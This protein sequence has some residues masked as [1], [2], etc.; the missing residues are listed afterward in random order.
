MNWNAIRTDH[1]GVADHVFGPMRPAV[2]TAAETMVC[3]LRAGGK[4]LCC[5]NGGSAADAQHFAAEILNRFET[6]HEPWPALALTTDSSVLTSIA[7]DYDY[8]EV[9]GKQVRGLGRPGD[10]LLAISTRGHSESVVRAAKAARGAGLTSIALTGADGG[11]LAEYCDQALIV[12]CSRVTARIQEGHAMIV[13]LLA[14]I[15]EE[16]MSEERSDLGTSRR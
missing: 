15:I 8:A 9:F 2:E 16:R 12:K 1:A 14:G 4:I 11:T 10:V 13:H 6:D 5:G 7:N 3:A